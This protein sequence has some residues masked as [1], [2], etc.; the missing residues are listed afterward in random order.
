LSVGKVNP[1]HPH[2]LP[3]ID[4]PAVLTN[5]LGDE[6]LNDAGVSVSWLVPNPMDFF[7]EFTLEVTGGP[8]SNPSFIRSP[9]SRYVYLAHLKNFWDLTENATLEL[10]LTGLTGPNAFE[11]TTTMGAFD[12][13]YKWKP[14][15]FNTYQSVIWQTEALLSSAG[16]GAPE[17]VLT[18]GMYS[19][20]TYQLDKRYFLTGRIDYSNLPT[21]ASEAERS[22][23][24]TLGWF[25]SEFQKIELEGKATTS[26]V[27]D[28]FSQ[29]WLR[30]VF[31]IGAHGA[32]AY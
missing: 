28:Q 1:L 26:N 15:R 7:Q 27:R 18:W 17:D 9:T 5:Y 10:G 4:L 16:T 14:L 11:H 32:H 6:G 24:A 19:S 25:A 13:T 20:L 12:L 3:F 21:S 29:A 30:W 2:A 31:V 8:S 23:S 22:C